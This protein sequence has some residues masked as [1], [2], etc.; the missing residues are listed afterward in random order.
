VAALPE[1]HQ[2]LWLLRA[3]RSGWSRNE[4]RRRLGAERRPRSRGSGL[5][6]GVRLS[7]HVARARERRWR[8]AATAAEQTF[9]DWVAQV[10]DEAAD[11][12]L[13]GESSAQGADRLELETAEASRSEGPL[14]GQ[15]RLVTVH[16][17]TRGLAA[18]GTR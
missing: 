10:V 17:A 6:D 13:A 15:D 7:L 11:A 9:S 8:Q 1:P 4:L 16:A 18:V 5:Q 2:D 12:A 3:E 14:G